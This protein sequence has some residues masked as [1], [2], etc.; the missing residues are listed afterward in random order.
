MFPVSLAAA[1]L[2]GP[3]A[4][5]G[6]ALDYAPADPRLK[7]VLIDRAEGAS[8]VAVRADSAGRVFVGGR[9]GLF[10]YE[11][12]PGGGYGPRRELYRFPPES[13][14]FDIEVR[15]HDLYAMTASA[16]YLLEGA[17]VRREGLAVRRL[18]W[19]QP[20][21]H[22]QLGFH[23]LA[24]GPEGDLYF[25]MGDALQHYG[26]FNRPDHWGHWT[27]FSQPE[28]TRT[29][30]TGVGGVLRCAPDGSRLE[31]VARGT[32]N[33]FG[34]AFDRAWS[35]FTNDNDRE[36]M[37]DLYVPARLLHVTPRAYFGWPRGW[38]ASK[39]PERS[40]LLETVYEGMGRAA[41]VGL[42]YYDE[43]FLPPEHR[44]C[45]LM[46]RWERRAVSRY[47][48]RPRGASFAAD[49]EP[50]LVGRNEARPLGVCE[51]R[52]GR[53]FVTVGYMAHLEGSPRY[54]S[55]LAMITTADD[56]P[57]HPFDG[58]DAPGASAEKLWAELSSPSWGRRSRAHVEL[59]RRG[60]P[61][62]AEAGRR[63]AGARAGDPAMGQLPWLAAASGTPEALR[64]LVELSSRGD[65]ALR[66]H[67]VRALAEH[68]G[69]GAPRSVFERALLD[70]EPKV[71][72]AALLVFFDLDGPPPEETVRGLVGSGDTYLRQ[73]AA[74]L[75]GERAPFAALAKLRGSV[76]PAARL[77]GVLAAGF[78][79]TLPPAAEPIPERVPLD[80]YPES[81]VVIQLADG[82]VD[83]RR[84]GRVGNFTSAERW[85]AGGHTE[86]EERLFDLLLEALG[87]GSERVRLQAA[88]FLGL[89]AD[90]RSEPRVAQVTTA[91]EERRL[92][93]APVT[94]LRDVAELWAVGPFPDGEDWLRAAH[95]PQTGPIDVAARYRVGDRTLAW[96]RVAGSYIDLGR[97]L[98]DA[99]RSS[100]YACCRLES[101][102]AQ[103]L[104]LFVGSDDGVQV[105]HNGALVLTA[106]AERRALRYD[107]MVMLR[108]APGSNDLL[109]R[110]H[111]RTGD[112][113]LCVSYKV[114]G[115]LEPALPQALDM[116]LLAE[117]LKA[118]GGPGRSEV[119][120]ALLGLGPERLERAV[121]GGDPRKGAELFQRLAC[122]GCH[123]VTA[124]QP[125]GVGPS[126]AEAAK[127]F[128]V[129][130]LVEAILLPGERVSPVF[131]ATLVKTEAGEV[132]T[133][134]AVAE[135][136]EELELVLPDTKRRTIP[137]R[138]I[139]AREVQEAS[140]MPQ[141]IVAAAEE[142]RDLV[143]YLLDPAASAP[144]TAAPPLP[145]P[146]P[147]APDGERGAAPPREARSFR[148]PPGLAI[149]KVAGP[150]LVRYPLFA[151][152]DD[153]GRLY[154]AE[155]T[156]TNLPGPE[157]VKLEL[158]RIALLEDSD[159]D[160]RFESGGTFADKLVAPQGVLWHEGVVYVAS[161]P[162]IWRLQDTDGDGRADRRE[163]L[164][165]KF[166]FNG[167]GCDIHGP[168]LGPDGW[169]YWTDG[170]H[171]HTCKTAEG[172]LL[173]GLAARI[174]RC[175]PDGTGIERICGGGFDNPVEL[176]FTESGEL[177]GTMDQGTGDA[178]LHYVLGGVY[179]RDDQP[180]LEE[181]PKT[182]PLLGA[183][184]TFSAALPV[185]LCGL[186]RIRS[187]RLGLGYQ[188]T[189][190]STQFNVHRIQQ[191]V[192]ARD[193]ATFR[194]S[195]KDFLASSDY[196]LRLTD[197]L[198]DADG[199]LL[200]V[201]MGAW[202]NYGC[203]TAKI[204]KPEVKGSIYRIRRAAAPPLDDPWGRALPLGS[205][206]S[207][208]L[209]RLL[210]DGRQKLRDRAG[211]RLVALGAEAV[212]AVAAVLRRGGAETGD[213]V[214][215][216]RLRRDAVWIL[217]R[218]GTPEAR[219][220]VRGALSDWDP[221]V[222]GAAA[223][224]AG[225]ER[226]A[227]ART[228][229]ASMAVAGEPPLRLRAAEALGR[230][231]G[232]GAVPALLESLRRGA[233]DRFLEHALIY[234]LIQIA[235]REA[236]LAAL[237][238]RTPSV[239][240]AGLIAL[241][242]MKGGGLR[243]E[244]VA[245]LL[246]TDDP[247][248]QAAALDVIGRNPAWSGEVLALAKGWLREPDL[249]ASQRASL[250]GSLLALAGDAAIQELIAAALASPDTPR[251]NRRLLLQV[252]ARSRLDPI[253]ARLLDAVARVLDGA[254]RDLQREAVAAARARS[255]GAFDRQLAELSRQREAPAELR[256]AALECTGPRRERLDP[257]AFALL[258][259]HLSEQSD[260]LLR[261]AAARTLGG[262]RLSR[263]QL[264]GLAALAASAGPLTLP[265]LVPAFTGSSDP[266]V[267]RALVEALRT[268]PGADSL[269]PD[270]L[271]GL[272]G[273]HSGEVHAAAEPLLA[274]LAERERDQE[275]YLTDLVSRTLQAA[276]DP[277]RGR[278]VFFSTKVG[279]YGCHRMEGKGGAVG[280]DLSQIGR[281][282]DP[283][284][285]LEAVVFP[286]STIV[287]EYRTY[288]IVTRGGEVVHG[289]IVRDASD[290]VHL[291]TSQL[292]EIRIA[293]T[294]IQAMEP[295]AVSIMPQGLEKTVTE[296][297]LA[298]LLEFLYGRR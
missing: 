249:P 140:P 288:T 230:I 45:L 62:L 159:G 113:G 281:I 170:R 43:D 116:G 3:L 176:A 5:A 41:P 35:L 272:L 215:G 23:G 4:A 84:L 280:P 136:I 57:S 187:D 44:G 36:A 114:L 79:L 154:V 223:H 255:L 241:D 73:S 233:I 182:G 240:R 119:P 29:P 222:R 71:Q 110:V 239:R 89:L 206:S 14:V 26:D 94:L 19:G 208:E 49:E 294:E 129:P 126:L 228:A 263:E 197:V 99:A 68:R 149:E 172:E 107:D 109:F 254:D 163:E 30:Y 269:T 11:P 169:L 8:F 165:G 256:I 162:S 209:V 72:H 106:D 103:P 153:R 292:A 246:D 131:R 78:R 227:E 189:L 210:E 224:C 214:L 156:G 212:E 76:D 146:P 257:E 80:P 123:A 17:A 87:D 236:T 13:W 242:Q 262:S 207:A 6:K 270:E 48:L 168:F 161:H 58:H 293:R 90:P 38:L 200:A 142:L 96:T 275:A 158:G 133:G 139:A 59:L 245:P 21:G 279:C 33:S 243:R 50:F 190:L 74:L 55:D 102:R 201:D 65:A 24:W 117:R 188:D 152:L 66:L 213:P 92:E 108:L 261:V 51:G 56:S 63:L 121:A 296:R 37:P 283:R 135:T 12:E 183:V 83:L 137:K 86:G 225:L 199:S 247:D 22:V 258:A 1:V 174:W 150:P 211:E 164:V 7:V 75:L 115:P 171:G 175:R 2:A 290:A 64:L 284:A 98:G 18:V 185:A 145:A 220:G 138:A 97:E 295:S 226:D 193:G 111:N 42:A 39:S 274:R 217:S 91:G 100:F 27:L 81:A 28:G 173:E 120:A 177:I 202:F 82:K 219:K 218:I 277:E 141:G 234:A 47:R 122:V 77:A 196:D 231:G 278:Q 118:A 298:D 221:S 238:E 250:A 251:E 178:L 229:L 54:R 88:H 95:P 282:R 205:M 204:A 248:L 134:L 286:S 16:L 232:A 10:A 151:C 235:D 105:W 124:A 93:G 31:V 186:E 34:L 61:L 143:A 70:P 252:I 112:S 60:G 32:F 52:G 266:E 291:R 127:R 155:G 147:A 181:L 167:N 191:H 265:L 285:L 20:L 237:G 198:E 166:G 125:G 260:P 259:A 289:M 67:A 9:E 132:L 46:A 104:M 195:S 268:S 25:T 157:L 264:L 40:D 194:A 144:P 273:R 130:Q 244:L 160:G 203:P 180:C 184:L 287:P 53:V 179:P 101:G 216:A 271:R 69:L 297:E 192:L 85:R 128:T 15:G 148:L 267:G 276:G 253:P